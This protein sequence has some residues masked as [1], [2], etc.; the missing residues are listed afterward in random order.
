MPEEDA[1]L[2]DFLDGGETADEGREREPGAGRD[3]DAPAGPAASTSRWVP[4][5]AACSGCGADVGRLWRDDGELVCSDC[6]EW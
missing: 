6:K 5:G 2:T 1:R 3:G 4:D